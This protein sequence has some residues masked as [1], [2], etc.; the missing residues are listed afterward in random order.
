MQERMLERRTSH[1]LDAVEATPAQ[2]SAI[3]GI[4]KAAWKDI[5]PMRDQ[6]R[7]S[8]E[9]G[10]ELMFAATIDRTAIEQLRA[11]QSKLHDAMGQRKLA[12]MLDAMQALTPEQRAKLASGKR[13]HRGMS[14]WGGMGEGQGHPGMRGGMP[15]R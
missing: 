7:A 12:G 2:R 15:P 10:R 6:Q 11:A 3:V 14:G 9:K 13:Q 5:K 4:A 8:R 1:M